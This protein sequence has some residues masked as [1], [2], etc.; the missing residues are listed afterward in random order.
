MDCPRC[1]SMQIVRY[2]RR[3]WTR[4]DGSIVRRQRFQCKRCKSIFSETTSKR[5][6]IVIL[7]PRPM[8]A[9]LFFEL[10]TFLQTNPNVRLRKGDV[11]LRELPT[12]GLASTYKRA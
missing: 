9:N 7:V 2:G 12:N 1:G 3:I 8:L 4:K 10:K 6:A 5:G 11:F